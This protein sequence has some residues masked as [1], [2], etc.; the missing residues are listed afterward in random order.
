MVSLFLEILKPCRPI[1]GLDIEAWNTIMNAGKSTLIEEH[2]YS[3][4]SWAIHDYS[5]TNLVEPELAWN[6][7][8]G[9]TTDVVSAPGQ[10]FF[11]T[12]KSGILLRVN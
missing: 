9:E 4:M 7:K 12:Y 10:G 1:D 5:R 11:F 3:W 6:F 2:I 8:N